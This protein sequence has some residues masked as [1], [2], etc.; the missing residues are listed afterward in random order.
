MAAVIEREQVVAWPTGAALGADVE[1]VDLAGPLSPE[2]L[3][4]IDEG[5]AAIKWAMRNVPDEG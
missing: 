2:T 5:E 4:A 1:G 3:A